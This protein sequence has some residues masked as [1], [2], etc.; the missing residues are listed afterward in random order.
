MSSLFQLHLP[1]LAIKPR[2]PLALRLLSGRIG[3]GLGPRGTEKEME[4]TKVFG[5]IE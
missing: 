4:A 1:P 5:D 3:M 2:D